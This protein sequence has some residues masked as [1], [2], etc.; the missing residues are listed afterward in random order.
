MTHLYIRHLHA[1]ALLAH[2]DVIYIHQD[3]ALQGQW[4]PLPRQKGH[5][6]HKHQFVQPEDQIIPEQDPLNTVMEPQVLHHWREQSS[7][8]PHRCNALSWLGLG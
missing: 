8:L 2:K 3:V 4:E 5:S 1:G 7:I 6:I